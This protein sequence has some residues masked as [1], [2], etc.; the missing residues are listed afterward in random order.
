MSK[1]LVEMTVRAGVEQH[2]WADVDYGASLGS[3]TAFLRKVSPYVVAAVLLAG[4]VMLAVSCKVS[5]IAFRHDS[6]VTTLKIEAVDTPDAMSRGLMGR[7]SLAANSGMLFDFGEEV[8]NAFYM[9]N[10]SIPL[11]IA[12][13][14][15]DGK[16]L[17]IENMKP[18]D[19]TPVAP[20]GK[21]RY[22]VEVNQ[23]W[24]SSNGIKA[25]TVA[26]IDRE[27]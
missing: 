15:L 8:E 27:R 10:T 5:S 21:Y 7:E 18:F 16:V 9:K 6:R 14:G 17:S 11:S 4:A 12:F 2:T 23:G 3:V 25:G 24:F 22:A 20:P 26:V 19:V 1:Y 13:I